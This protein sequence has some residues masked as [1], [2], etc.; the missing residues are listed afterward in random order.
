MYSQKWGPGYC[1]ILGLTLLTLAGSWG[2]AA[3]GQNSTGSTSGAKQG[4]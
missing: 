2:A 3:S 4:L 1:V